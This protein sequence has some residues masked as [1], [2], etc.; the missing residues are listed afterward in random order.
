MNYSQAINY[1]Y[2]L[3]KFGMNFGLDRIYELL[4]LLGNPH[5]KLKIVHV[6]G[7]NGKGSTCAMLNAILIESGYKVGLF[8]SPH[9]HSYRERF[10]INNELITQ[11]SIATYI[12]NIRPLL[13]QMVSDG[14]EHPT[15]FEVSTAVALKYFYDE[16]VDVLILEVGLGGEI[17]S[18]NVADNPLLSIITNVAMDHTAYL[19]NTLKEIAAIKAGIIKYQRPIITAAT[20]Q[21]VLGV[22]HE[23]AMEKDAPLYRIDKHFA[24]ETRYLSAKGSGFDI[25]GVGS[26]YPDVSVPLLGEHQGCNAA[27]A[28]VASEVLQQLGYSRITESTIYQGIGKV[29]WEGRLEVLCENPLILID[30]AHN[31]DGIT[32]LKK[33]ID[34]LFPKKNMTLILSMLADKERKEAVELIAPAAKAIFVTRP[35][36]PRAGNWETMGE[37]AQKYCDDVK[38]V[39]LIDQAVKQALEQLG[40]GDLLVVTGSFY[41]VSEARKLLQEMLD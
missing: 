34:T 38:I 32:S 41:M 24:C 8:T 23:K 33:A 1:L 18:T 39:P 4:R 20:N 36:S 22:L 28:I 29:I 35:L 7:T 26:F 13:K 2:D 10:R 9:L 21:D 14:F 16:Q 40:E 25:K 12:T 27:L 30:V 31:V 3:T 5:Q 37:M 17:D 15:E 19:G 6:G 11:K